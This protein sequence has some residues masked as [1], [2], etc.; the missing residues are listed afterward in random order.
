MP[1]A[2]LLLLCAGLAAA[3]TRVMVIGL[4]GCSPDGIRK[5]NAPNLARMRAQGA[6]TFK[7][8]GVMPTVSS[9]NWASM[10]MGAGPEQHGITSNEWQPDKFE[11][12]AVFLGSRGRFPT[13]FGVLRDQRPKARIAVIHD[14]TG[15]GRLVEPGVPDVMENP[16]GGEATVARAIEVWNSARPDLL[17]VHIDHADHAGH[18]KGHGTPE[19]YSAVSEVDAWIG[20]LAEAAGNAWVLVTADHGGKGKKHGGN[21]LEELEIPWILTGPGAARGREIQSPV[22]TVDTAAAVAHIFKLKAPDAWVGRPVR[23]AFR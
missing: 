21:T 16:K 4:D 15:F 19:Y 17:F 5:A 1:S 7:A 20:R 23:E 10:I 3:Q 18:E 8:R 12:P 22:N 2:A 13:I 14:W 6:W 11:F 9:P